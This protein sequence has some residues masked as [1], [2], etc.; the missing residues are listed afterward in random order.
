MGG[1]GESD[2]ETME[3]RRKGKEIISGVYHGEVGGVI[4]HL[5]LWFCLVACSAWM[6]F[7]SFCVCLIGWK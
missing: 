6:G 7:E 2:K 3:T 1:G 5:F 4:V